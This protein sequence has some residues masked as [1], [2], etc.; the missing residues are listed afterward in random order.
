MTLEK[1]IRRASRFN[2]EK[3]AR[4]YMGRDMNRFIVLGD[5]ELYWVVTGSQMKILKNAGYTLFR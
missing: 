5:D 4:N 2:T 3:N 1:I